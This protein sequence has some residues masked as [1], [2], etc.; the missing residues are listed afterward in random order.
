MAQVEFVAVMM[1]IFRSYKVTPVLEKG[2]NMNMARD[3]LMGVIA[4]SGPRVTLQMN[5]PKD[6][7][8]RWEAR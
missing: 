7:K 4:D 5:R 3:R 2:E 6:V 1:T 8:L